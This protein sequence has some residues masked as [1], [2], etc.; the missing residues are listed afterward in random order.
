MRQVH[1]AQ[2]LA[3]AHIIKG[4]LDAEGIASVVR[5]EHL[6]GIQG[7]IPVTAD[8]L[9]SVWVPDSDA[10]RASQL[11]EE[12]LQGSIQGDAWTCPGCGEEI[13]GQFTECWQCG[14]SHP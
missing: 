9:P 5:G 7:E 1:I 14:T 3:E 4:V 13:E 8:T 10:E 2:T 12:I 6:V 11:V